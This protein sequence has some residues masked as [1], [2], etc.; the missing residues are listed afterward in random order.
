MI[1]VYF[2]V[3][4]IVA[5]VG[6]AMAFVGWLFTILMALGNKDCMLGALC[7]VFFPL[8]WYYS[9]KNWRKDNYAGGLL[10]SGTGLL[11]ISVGAGWLLFSQFNMQLV[12]Q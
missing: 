3:L 1:S 11:A 6:A 8:A 4:L 12:P 2:T 10:F 5:A 9:A 7:F